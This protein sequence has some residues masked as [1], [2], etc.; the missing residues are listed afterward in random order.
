MCASLHAG[1][2]ADSTFGIFEDLGARTH[3]GK[4]RPL[5]ARAAT[6]ENIFDRFPPVKGAFVLVSEDLENLERYAID[7]QN[8]PFDAVTAELWRVIDQ[9]AT[10]LDK[11]DSPLV[12]GSK[13]LHH[14]LPELVPPMDRANTGWFLAWGPS[15]WTR[16]SAKVSFT[17]AMKVFHV[18]ALGAEPRRL[19][20]NERWRTS[21]SKLVDNAIGGSW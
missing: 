13:A 7:D 10:K 8:L 4:S 9:V 12:L 21:T 20:T 11:R 15:A 5:V 2:S 3:S 18:I 16:S 1:R 17:R 14:V 6:G 19:V